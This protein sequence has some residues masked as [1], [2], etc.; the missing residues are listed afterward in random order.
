MRSRN[1]SIQMTIYNQKEARN[2]WKTFKKCIQI[3]WI[4]LSTLGTLW[5]KMHKLFQIIQL[6]L[7]WPMLVSFQKL[8]KMNLLQNHLMWILFPPY[9]ISA[10][11]K[12]AEKEEVFVKLELVRMRDRISAARETTPDTRHKMRP[13]CV[14]KSHGTDRPTDR[15]PTCGPTD[16]RMDGRTRPLIEMQRRI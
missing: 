16:G 7:T 11:N 3:T 15:R 10:T 14:W 13:V 12:T 4:R 9:P 2:F 5:I 6:I 1:F 8:M